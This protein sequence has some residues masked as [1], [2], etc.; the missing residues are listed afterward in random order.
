MYALA[1]EAVTAREANDLLNEYIGDRRRGIIVFHDHFTGRP[2]GGVAVWD[3]RSDE[4]AALLDD[5]GPL[6]G[7]TLTTHPL[8]F[9]LTANGFAAQTSLTL[10]SYGGTTL[11]QVAAEEGD[12]E[13]FWWRR[14]A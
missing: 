4:E 8:T 7:W 3:V 11:E 10:E 1:P 5:P 12:D 2:H 9:S 13:R 6:A 14:R